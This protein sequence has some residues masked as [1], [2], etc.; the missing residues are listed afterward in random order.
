[1]RAPQLD[2]RCAIVNQAGVI[3][4]GGGNLTAQ[5]VLVPSTSQLPSNTSI[6]QGTPR[7]MSIANDNYRLFL[8][9]PFRSGS[10]RRVSTSP[11]AAA[12]SSAATT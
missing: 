6:F 9:V 8:A 12:C 11:A 7:F 2:L 4:Q 10:G 5:F 1:M 3:R